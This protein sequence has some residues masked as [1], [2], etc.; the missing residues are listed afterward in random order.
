M[1][2]LRSFQSKE[3][4]PK[5]KIVSDKDEDSNYSYGYGDE[6]LDYDSPSK[7]ATEMENILGNALALTERSNGSIHSL[8]R[9][10]TNSAIEIGRR[11]G[12]MHSREEMSILGGDDLSHT[13]SFS[14]LSR[15]SSLGST[16]SLPTFVRVEGHSVPGILSQKS[17]DDTISGRHEETE[18]DQIPRSGTSGRSWNKLR[19]E[20]YEES[21]GTSLYEGDDLRR[22]R[23]IGRR[24]LGFS[25]KILRDSRNIALGDAVTRRNRSEKNPNIR[26]GYAKDY[27]VEVTLQNKKTFWD[28]TP[29][30]TSFGKGKKSVSAA[31]S[32]SRRGRNN[33]KTINNSLG[34]PKTY[35][36]DSSLVEKNSNVVV[37]MHEV[38]QGD[39]LFEA[40]EVA[41]CTS[42]G[43]TLDVTTN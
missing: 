26:K 30:M 11:I 5:A 1:N 29:S 3:Q 7:R 39:L 33:G 31:L 40:L 27:D 18:D 13:D 24:A 4:H 10:G 20:V 12:S 16:A 42:N 17:W 36:D 25:K 41:C 34:T 32:R 21:K 23:S 14:N 35:V 38:S 37:D 15:S 2:F 8:G 9:T 28:M 43:D 19:R 6:F 22:S